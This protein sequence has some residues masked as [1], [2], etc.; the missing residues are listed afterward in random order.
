MY[1]TNSIF[2]VANSEYKFKQSTGF[3]WDIGSGVPLYQFT[4]NPAS[5]STQRFYFG[6]NQNILSVSCPG[7]ALEV[8]D[9][10][11]SN[12]AVIQINRINSTSTPQT[13]TIDYLN[14]TEFQIL[15][16]PCINTAVD[17]TFAST[18]DGAKVQLYT[19]NGSGAQRF[20]FVPVP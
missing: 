11:C 7:C 1:C 20:R 4:Q 16:P 9:G 8:K 17:I 19:T 2:T 5:D 15:H 14:A 10:S 3:Q 6:P 13:F 18:A 12:G